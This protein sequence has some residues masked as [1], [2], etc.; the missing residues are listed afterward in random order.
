MIMPLVTVGVF[1][2]G[3]IERRFCEVPDLRPATIEA[4][5]NHLEE[6]DLVF[7]VYDD[8]RCLYRSAAQL[9]DF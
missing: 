9:T 5:V 3:Q 2:A 4:M 7:W 8:Q 1:N 6:D